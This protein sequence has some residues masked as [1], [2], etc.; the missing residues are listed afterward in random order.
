MGKVTSMTTK[1]HY[2]DEDYTICVRHEE[3]HSCSDDNGLTSNGKFVYDS[4]SQTQ[5]GKCY[6]D[7]QPTEGKML[8]EN[9]A[10]FSRCPQGVFKGDWCQC[11]GNCGVW[12]RS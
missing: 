2:Q 8:G 1:N 7:E 4:V 12:R 9:D 6:G 11:P 3:L 10:Y 5:E